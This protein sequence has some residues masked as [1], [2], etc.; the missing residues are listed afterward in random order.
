MAI[1][2]YCRALA[3]ELLNT[4]TTDEECFRDTLAAYY[5]H[6]AWSLPMPSSSSPRGWTALLALLLMSTSS[7]AQMVTVT[8]DLDT[9][10]GTTGILTSVTAGNAM[11]GMTVN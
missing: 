5:P 3:T 2:L 8:Q 10:Q 4:V 6:S 9:T 7:P 11:G 1:G